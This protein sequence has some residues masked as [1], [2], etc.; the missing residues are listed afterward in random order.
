MKR[1]AFIAGLGGALAWPVVARAQQPD[2]MRRI[3]L[4]MFGDENDPEVKA[5][6]PRFTQGL[7]E[8][9]WTDGRNLRMDVRW[10]AAN[11]ELARMYAKEL[12][13]LQPDVIVATAFSSTAALQRVTRTIPIV[14][15]GVSDPIDSGFVA[16]L[17]RPGGN[18]TGFINQEESL[19]GKLLQLLTEIAP[20]SSGPHS[21]STPTRLPIAA[22]TYPHSSPLPVRSKWRPSQRPFIA[23]PKSKRS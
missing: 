4:L 17:A 5:L 19:A 13:D 22:I 2:R 21:C 20:P 14:F 1:R 12:V 18:M 10:T 6:L 8:L 9:G 11:V 16:S 3:G 15:V 7:A 23:T